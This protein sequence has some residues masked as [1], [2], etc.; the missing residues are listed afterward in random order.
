MLSW[1]TDREEGR[2]R[3]GVMTAEVRP[4]KTTTKK[5]HITVIFFPL[6]WNVVVE[7]IVLLLSFKAA[8]ED[9]APGWKCKRSKD[10][11]IFQ[12][13]VPSPRQATPTRQL[14][15]RTGSR[16]QRATTKQFHS[17]IHAVLQISELDFSFVFSPVY[18]DNVTL[19]AR[20]SKVQT[21]EKSWWCSWTENR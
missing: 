21:G 5:K 18:S 4:K 19:D 15:F 10:F 8:V 9:V 14:R 17:Q 6:R 11:F 1:Q 16:C 13:D 3:R 12:R 2:R 7:F 20:S